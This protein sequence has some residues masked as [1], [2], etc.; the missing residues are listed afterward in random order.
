VNAGAREGG[1]I[2][3]GLFLEHFIKAGIPWAHLDIAGPA[4]G[5][6]A[7]ALGPKGATG[8]GVRTLF[9]LARTWKNRA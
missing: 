3:A 4:F 1:S 5:D 6:K 9:E 8:F 7:H 2:F